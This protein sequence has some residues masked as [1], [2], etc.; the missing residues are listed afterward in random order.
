[1]RDLSKE[2][3]EGSSESRQNLIP[4]LGPKMELS[5]S[6]FTK[7][8]VETPHHKISWKHAETHGVE[9]YVRR[10]D[11][12]HPLLSGNKI[13]KLFGHLSRYSEQSTA[14]KL[15]SFGGAYSNHLHALAS[16]GYLNKLPTIGVIRGERP[17]SPSQTLRDLE[18]MGMQL[19]FVTRG[20]YRRKS[21]PLFVR[22][23]EEK[24]A[25]VGQ[26][27]WIPEGA[28]G[29]PGL[30]GCT[31]LGKFLA[32]KPYDLIALACGTGTTF[33]GILEG[34]RERM[35]TPKGDRANLGKALLGVSALRNSFEVVKLLASNNS[36]SSTFGLNWMINNEFHCG[37][38]A[39]TNED[40]DRFMQCFEQET[41]VPVEK[42]YSGKLFYALSK[43]IEHG[44]IRSGT[45]LL[46]IHSGGLQGKRGLVGDML[47]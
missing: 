10:D 33:R 42:V 35:S 32:E 18:S 3:S 37:G 43:M 21:D 9:V 20:E 25:A 8:L 13:Y 19:V 6:A 39:K 46:A 30:I 7:T 38:F 17:W 1:M 11:L 31:A 44:Q 2:K 40:L 29:N 12:I 16:Y 27:F 36:A 28:G 5:A 15:C 41:T 34:L 45:R 24:L 26:C 14:T 4:S 47:I 22:K 23:I